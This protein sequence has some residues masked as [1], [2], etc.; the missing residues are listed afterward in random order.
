MMHWLSQLPSWVAFV[1]T[2]GIANAAAV[3]TM[4]VVRHWSHE[5]GIESGPAVV[6]SW[7][8][9]A[10]ALCAVLFAFSIVTLWSAVARAR[11]NVDDEATAVR[12]IA[13]DLVPAQR[14]LLAAYVRGS[15]NEWPQLCD[16]RRRT[17]VDAAL[18]GLIRSA[19]ARRPAYDD[20]LYRELA[21]LEDL[22]DRRWEFAASSIPAEI[23]G[24]LLVTAGALLVVL[25]VALPER[26]GTHAALMLAIATSLGTL[27][28]V[29]IV[30]DHPFCGSAAMR[31]AAL[32]E[33]V[34]S[35]AMR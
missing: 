13:R 29:M 28:W 34:Q 6:N 32:V 10:G 19:K 9:A 16:G 25:A 21:M 27:L 4:A 15:V 7:A 20:D 1:I 31:P 30:L 35:H 3:A 18:S 14:P 2:A 5:A 22:R 26:R 8:T 33:A 23:W 11:A 24:G 17:S 12:A